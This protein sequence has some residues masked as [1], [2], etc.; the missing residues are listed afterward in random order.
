MLVMALTVGAILIALGTKFVASVETIE[1]AASFLGLEGTVLLA[2]AFSALL[3]RRGNGGK[4][5]G[6]WR[7]QKLSEVCTD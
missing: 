2:S 7:E 6:R 1:A 5:G 3:I 4:T